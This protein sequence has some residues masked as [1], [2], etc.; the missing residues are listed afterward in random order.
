MSYL[1]LQIQPKYNIEKREADGFYI[2]KGG[3]CHDSGKQR[4]CSKRFKEV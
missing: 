1:N 4:R 2:K 3:I